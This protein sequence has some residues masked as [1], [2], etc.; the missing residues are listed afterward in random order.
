MYSIFI[1]RP[2]YDSSRIP[3]DS[4]A[5]LISINRHLTFE[6]KDISFGEESKATQEGRIR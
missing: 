4:R 6:E 3:R 1:R 2:I 5:A